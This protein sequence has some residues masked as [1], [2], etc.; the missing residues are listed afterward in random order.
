MKFDFIIGN[1]PYQE[2][3]EATS[4]KPVYHMFMDEVYAIC[5]KVCLITPARFLFNAGKTPKAWNKKMLSDEHLKVLYYEQSSNNVF[6]NTDIKGGVAITYRDL[7]KEYG[8]IEHFVPNAVLREILEKVR[9][10]KNFMSFA[11]LVN[12][13]E[14]YKISDKMYKEHP[15][16]LTKKII[17]K[18]KEVPLISAGHENDLTSNILDKN[19]IVFFEEEP[20]D[21]SKYCR[22]YGRQ[23]GERVYRYIRADYLQTPQAL[24]EYKIVVPESNNSGAFGETLVEPFVAEPGVATTQTFITIGGFAT[25]TQADNALKYVK[26]KFAR[27]MLGTLKITQHNKRDTWSNIPIQ[28]FEKTSDIDWSGARK[29][30]DS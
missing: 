16:L 21:A 15:E 27:A 3:Q 6:P 8:S 14:Y 25:K 28:D 7:K 26:S 29:L 12:A 10:S 18:G 23:G 5:D 11:Q 17:I 9:S 30:I 4:D 22:V 13:T 2:T 1:P 19:D 24:M 20:K